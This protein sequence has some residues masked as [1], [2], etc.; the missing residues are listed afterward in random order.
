MQLSKDEVKKKISE[1][2]E[3]SD[4]AIELLEIIEDS[5]DVAPEIDTSELEDMK[6]KYEDLQTKYKERFLEIKESDNK[7]EE[8]KDELSEEEI[9]DVKEI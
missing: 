4:K 8:K 5:M 7:E 3:D 9:V 1:L 6:K 2:V